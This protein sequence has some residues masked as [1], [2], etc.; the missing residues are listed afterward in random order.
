MVGQMKPNHCQKEKEDT[1]ECLSVLHLFSSERSSILALPQVYASW[2]ILLPVGEG[3]AP[4][5][6]FMIPRTLE[7]H[8]DKLERMLACTINN[9]MLLGS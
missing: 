4:L 6:A 3:T 7:H 1:K 2:N 5:R 8:V 9:K